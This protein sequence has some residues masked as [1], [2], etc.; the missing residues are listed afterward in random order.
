MHYSITFG[1]G[2]ST[3]NT[4]SDW[5]LV[6]ESPPVIPSPRP[7]TN[8]VDIPGRIFGPLDLSTVPFGYMTWER[9]TGNWVFVMYDDYWHTPDR[10]AV[11]EAVRSWLH[12]RTTKIVLE[13]DPDHY[14]YG[15]FTVEAPRSGQ[16]PFALQIGYDLEP[17]RYN[18]EDDSIDDEW[19]PV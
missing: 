8:Y 3:K 11:Y 12:G 9:M 7:K 16:G 5:K 14:F 2:N 19:L 18:T 4:W 1:E 17:V 10:K 6:P 15:R 13:E